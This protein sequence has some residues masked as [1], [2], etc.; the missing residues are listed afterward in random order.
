MIIKK[1]YKQFWKFV[2]K[3]DDKLNNTKKVDLSSIVK[4]KYNIAYGADKENNLF[5]I[6][7]PIKAQ[8]KLPTIIVMHGGG[9]VGGK[10]E[11]DDQY[12]KQ[13]ASRGFCVVNMEF[14]RCN[15]K[16]NKFF[17]NQ[18]ANFY[19]MYHYLKSNE[20]LSKFVDYDNIFLS[21]DSA[22]GHLIEMIANIQTNKLLD[23]DK[24]LLNGP[25]IKGVILVSPI[26][27]PFKLAH[28]PAKF[29]LK[30][31]IY[32]PYKKTELLNKKQHGFDLL[33]KDFPATIMFSAKNDFITRQHKKMFLKKAQRLKFPLEHYDIMNGYKLFHSSIMNY[34]DF[35]PIC[36]DKIK[37]FVKN[38]VK[39]KIKNCLKNDIIYE[40][41]PTKEEEKEL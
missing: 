20:E 1:L 3:K 39:G 35:Y 8:R 41:I 16:E 38:V 33:S 37:H 6:H 22:G 10:K 36:L 13:L 9:Y 4:S 2:Q 40:V 7:Y 15:D 18:I 28:L 31:L 11:N 25:N 14:Y 24:S 23:K 34:P 27:G 21:G 30:P 5:D 19:D 26:F 32:G 29:F 17:M 12:S